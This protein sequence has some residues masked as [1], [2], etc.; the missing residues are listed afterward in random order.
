MATLVP[1]IKPAPKSKTDA[2]VVYHAEI[3]EV[4]NGYEESKLAGLGG[5]EP[6]IVA[7]EAEA[8]D[9]I[10]RRLRQVFDS[11]RHTIDWHHGEYR[12]VDSAMDHI[13]IDPMAPHKEDLEFGG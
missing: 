6:M 3:S 4:M 1:T 12:D 5:P 13:R 9:W 2:T 10:E 8:V 7:T 11:S